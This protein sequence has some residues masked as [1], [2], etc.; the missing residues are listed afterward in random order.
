M[1]ISKLS[2]FLKIAVTSVFFFRSLN[3]SK[4]FTPPFFSAANAFNLNSLGM[5][6]MTSAIIKEA[7]LLDMN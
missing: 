2:V 7:G 1:F 4:T 6:N 5:T 3:Q